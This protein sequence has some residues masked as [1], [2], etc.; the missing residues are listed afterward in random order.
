MVSM[1]NY[2]E[3]TMFAARF[4]CCGEEHLVVPSNEPMDDEMNNTIC[5]YW[6]CLC[7]IG[8]GHMCLHELADVLECVGCCV[9]RAHIACVELSFFLLQ[10]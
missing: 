2:S 8:V 1:P 5:G 6:N 10:T 4:N 9:D 7:D 3:K